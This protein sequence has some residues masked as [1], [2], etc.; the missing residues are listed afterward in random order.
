MAS[1][2]EVKHDTYEPAKLDVL[3]HIIKNANDGGQKQEYEIE[4]DNFKVVPRTSDPERFNT[5][6]DFITPNT[7]IVTIRMFRGAARTADVFHF[8][9]K[10]VPQTLQSLNGMPENTTQDEW[11]KKQKEKIMREIRYEQLEKENAEMTGELEEKEK[12]IGELQTKLKEAI[13]GKL[14]RYKDIGTALLEGVIASPF[15]KKNFPVINELS[16]TPANAEVKQES[17]EESASFKRKGESKEEIAEV[18]SEEEQGYLQLIRDLEARL[19]EPQ[20]DN[21]MYLLGQL[22]KNPAAIASTLKHISNFI[23]SKPKDINEKV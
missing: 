9:I 6:S 19:T 22:V 17:P 11:E 2:N 18:L 16:G 4:L 23:N 13:E 15:I 5:F 20:L 14:T 3:L 21:V 1:V 12:I 10:G 7:K 8:H